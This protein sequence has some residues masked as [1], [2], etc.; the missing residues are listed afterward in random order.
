[1]AQLI[2]TKEKYGVSVASRIDSEIAHQI[3]ERAERLGISFAKMV[4]MLIV[5]GF[6]PQEPIKVESREE[7][8]RLEVEIGELEE[9]IEIQNFRQTQE[10]LLYKQTA[11]EFINRISDDEEEQLQ[12]ATIYNEILTEQKELQ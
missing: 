6:N 5:R 12:N 4:G 7:I 9:T 3:S 10:Q 2:T 11:A 1:M 8:E